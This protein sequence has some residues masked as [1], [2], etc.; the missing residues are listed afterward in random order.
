VDDLVDEV[1]GAADAACH[2]VVAVVVSAVN[3]DKVAEITNGAS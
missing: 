2:F 3:A 1:I